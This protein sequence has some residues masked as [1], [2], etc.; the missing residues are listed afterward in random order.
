MLR[1]FYFNLQVH[2]SPTAFN[3]VSIPI[4][5]DTRINQKSFILWFDTKHILS[6]CI[7]RPCSSTRKPAYTS[8]SRTLW[9]CWISCLT[10]NIR[11]TLADFSF[12]IV[13]SRNSSFTIFVSSV[14]ISKHSLSDNSPS[15][16]MIENTGIFFNTR[17]ENNWRHNV[18]TSFYK[19]R[20]TKHQTVRSCK[21]FFYRFHT[22]ACLFSSCCRRKNS[23]NLSIKVN[24][25]FFNWLCSIN[26][27]ILSNG[28]DKP[29]SIP[30]FFLNICIQCFTL[31]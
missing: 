28:P 2:F 22:N 3:F 30:T 29:F 4:W 7:I 9:E 25:P 10:N 17:K 24:L 18:R 14:T 13:C 15:L 31:F 1:I 21:F 11:F 5:F 26:S 6:D 20:S 8:I 27:S 16:C 12:I 23:P 19:W